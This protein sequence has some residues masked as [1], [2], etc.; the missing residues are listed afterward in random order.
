MAVLTQPRNFVPLYVNG[1][2]DT[3]VLFGLKNV[4]AGDT[5]DIALWLQ[6]INRAAVI[7]VISFVEIAASWSGT[8]VTMPGGLSA[9]TGYLLVWGAGV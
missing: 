5:A 8:V 3:V 1:S 4:T 6:I 7:G 9:D 2:P